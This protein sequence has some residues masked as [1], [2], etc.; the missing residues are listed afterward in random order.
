M[1][2]EGHL[3]K[4][5]SA[6]KGAPQRTL[7]GAGRVVHMAG[8]QWRVMEEQQPGS[9]QGRGAGEKGLERSRR[10]CER[11]HPPGCIDLFS[12]PNLPA[13]CTPQPPGYPQYT[14]R[15]SSSTLQLHYDKA[16]AL[17]VCPEHAEIRYDCY[18]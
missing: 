1:E 3:G 2:G 15:F 4:L 17:N 7:E 6:V 18:K 16:Y 13:N 9:R 12:L 14:R 11:K 5:G 8:E 10:S